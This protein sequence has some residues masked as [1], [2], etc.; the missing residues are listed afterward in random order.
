MSIRKIVSPSVSEPPPN[1]FS[2]C[3]VV[4]AKVFL[5]GM[6]ASGADGRAIGGE[7]MAAQARVV[8]TKIRHLLEAAGA[9]M[10]DIVKLTVYVTDISRR[11]EINRVRPEFFADPFPCSTLVEIKALVNPDLLIEIDAVALI[12]AGER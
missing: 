5:S 4:G 7:D 8:L 3:L 2:N 6:T 10:G 12:G 9:T 11:P 1:T